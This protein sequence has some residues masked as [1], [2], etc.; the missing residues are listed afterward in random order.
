[1]N[2]FQPKKPDTTIWDVV[3]IGTGM[4]GSTVGYELSKSGRK[5]L[6]IEKGKFLF[7]NIDRGSGKLPLD[8]DDRPDFR[9]NRGQWPL[10]L[11]GKTS[12]GNIEFYAP[13]GCGTGGSSNLY[14]AQL[15]RLS[16]CD[17]RP[18]INYPNVEDTTLPEEWP[19]SYND[20]LPYYRRA[21][22]LY[23]VRG[24]ED[25]LNQDPDT[26]YLLPPIM[27]ER[28]QDFNEHFI[29]AGLHPYRAHVA[30]EFEDDCG[31]CGGV[32]CPKLCKNDA[33]KICLLPALKNGAKILTEC[34][35]MLLK[36]NDKVIKSVLC[37]LNNKEINIK[38]K[39][40]VLA[41]GSLFSPVLLLKSK[42]EVWPNGLANTSGQVGRNLMWH[43]SDFIAARPRK[44]ISISGPK[45]AI[46]LNDFYFSDGVKLG[47]FQSIG[48]PVT[49]EYVYSFLRSR[50]QKSPRWQRAIMHPFLLKLISHIAALLFK[51]TAIFATITEDLP[52][53]ENRVI[54]DQTAK[55]EMRFNYNYKEELRSRAE[56]FCE[57]VVSMLKTRYLT[58]KLTGKNNINYGHCCGTCRFGSDPITSVLDKNNRCHDVENLYVVD[59]SFFPSSGGTNPSLTIA[60]NA[61]RVAEVISKRFS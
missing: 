33:G 21:E 25:P 32:L 31:E 10:P 23:R 45:K 20:L 54:F 29:K 42:S 52:Y 12:F 11:E 43:V 18:R 55:N 19:I 34:E 41:A 2:I 50:S 58:F 48:V 27:S 61:I 36:S 24:T 35:V 60:A 4:G 47:A 46:S 26:E 9:L 22:K 17:F 38:G 49:W 59:S 13:L 53:S 56:L 44:A 16:P 30:S 3:I 51:N 1:M 6:F 5:V 39:I 14:A 15:E 8:R 7:G 40:F 57:K 37:K 28:D